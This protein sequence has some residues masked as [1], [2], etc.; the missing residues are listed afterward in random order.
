MDATL[1]IYFYSVNFT[2]IADG[3][4]I[5]VRLYNWPVKFFDVRPFL[6]ISVNVVPPYGAAFFY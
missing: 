5:F 1:L 6:D 2:P 3:L 4:G